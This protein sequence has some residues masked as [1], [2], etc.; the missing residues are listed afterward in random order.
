MAKEIAEPSFLRRRE[1]RLAAAAA[2]S[3]GEK[4]NLKSKLGM[5][6]KMKRPAAKLA[7]KASAKRKP[8]KKGP[9]TTHAG[10]SPAAFPRKVWTKLQVTKSQKE[11][12]RAYIRGTTADDGKPPPPLDC[13]DQAQKPCTVFRN[14]AAHQRQAGA[15]SLDKR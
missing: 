10:A 14:F 6:A 1:G 5:V 15:G 4:A 11:P 3:A 7:K 12:W 9:V 13:G 8:L 2:S